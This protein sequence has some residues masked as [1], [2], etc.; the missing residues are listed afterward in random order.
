MKGLEGGKVLITFSIVYP[1]RDRSF[2]LASGLKALELQTY[3]NF[4]VV[5][6]DNPSDETAA[7]RELCETSTELD[8]KYVRAPQDS[9]MVANWNFALEKC[10]GDY[11]IFLTDKMSLLPG[12]LERVVQSVNHFGPT[13]MVSW[14]S[15]V[16]SPSRFPDY[17][18][19]GSYHKVPR[20][21]SPIHRKHG[22]PFDPVKE[23]RRR[24][25][26]KVSR[27]NQHPR[28]YARGKIIFGAYS[29]SMVKRIQE[30]HGQLF[31]PL[32]ADY[33][34]MIL[35][36]GMARDSIELEKSGVVSVNTDI[37]NG[38][39]NATNDQRALT[40]LKRSGQLKDD[41]DNMV[42]PGLYS[43]QHAIVSIDYKRM[44]ARLEADIDMNVKNW[45]MHCF[46][47]L[48]R[49]D[50]LWSS[51]AVKEEQ[52]SIYREFLAELNRS[53]RF[54]LSLSLMFERGL[55]IVK[56]KFGRLNFFASPPYLPSVPFSRFEEIF[57]SSLEEKL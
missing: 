11:I 16:Y 57:A 52:F 51:L 50:R 27:P 9:T 1:T 54:K 13:D 25:K 30:E 19:P 24:A 6:S 10:S 38:E 42:V 39:L 7:V 22:T 33:T 53:Q 49:P 28:D 37:S 8:I 5:V 34:S 26:A 41:L 17:L 2:L 47:D 31:W 36:L 3:R 20:R 43:A 46:K 21:N 14:P 12:I 18:G 29:M 55:E 56:K 35:G 4:E 44:I 23:L 15:D 32:S 40:G 48:S 45:T